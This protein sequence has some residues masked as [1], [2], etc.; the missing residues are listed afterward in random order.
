MDDLTE[1]GNRTQTW[2]PEVG[3]LP[4]AIVP[5]NQ[6]PL[7]FSTTESAN[8]NFYDCRE[9]N[10]FSASEGRLNNLGE[11]G[12]CFSRS[13]DR[14]PACH[15]RGIGFQ[16][17]TLQGDTAGSISHGLNYKAW[18]NSKSGSRQNRCTTGRMG[19]PV[20][21][22]PAFVGLVVH[23]SPVTLDDVNVSRIISRT[24]STFC[25]GSCHERHDHDHRNEA[26]DD[27]ADA[28]RPPR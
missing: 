13:W 17:V 19:Q 16:P 7:L 3:R 22:A 28:E 9:N 5:R 6:F 4:G 24:C 20:P 2:L 1:E 25:R 27:R 23:V 21:A 8:F 14:L 15:F 18:S 10:S 26:A 12:D 11:T